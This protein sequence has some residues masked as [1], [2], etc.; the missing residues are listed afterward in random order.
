MKYTGQISTGQYEFLAFELETDN[1]YE[2]VSAYEDLRNAYRSVQEAKNSLQAP[3]G[4]P[5]R[6]WCA[7]MDSYVS[8]GKL[9]GGAE[10]WDRMSDYQRQVIQELKRCFARTTK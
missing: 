5:N 1:A 9:E 2:S 3:L 7:V 4:L 6:E 8:T 10:I